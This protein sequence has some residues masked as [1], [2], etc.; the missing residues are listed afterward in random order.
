VTIC[1]KLLA[2]I[3]AFLSAL[4][5][6][7]AQQS[8]K[9]HRV[10]ELVL[11]GGSS[12]L[13]T[14]RE[15]FRRELHGL[16]YIEGKNIY[17]ETRSAEGNA[18][19]FNA[20]AEEL[21]RLKV[22]AIL[23]TSPAET[24]AARRATT[25]IPIVFLAQGDPVLSGLVD[26][27]SRPGGNVTGVTTVAAGLSGKRLELLKEVMPKLFRAAVLWNPQGAGEGWKESQLAAKEL[28]LQLHSMQVNSADGVESTFKEALKA[29]SAAFAV[30]QNP[31]TSIISKQVI[32][33]ARTHP[34]PTIFPRGDYVVNGGL[35]S[36]GA[37]QVESFRRAAH[38]VDKI[39]KGTKPGDLPV[40]RPTK[41]YLTISLK[42][43]KQIG[44]AISPN[45]LA[46]ADRVIK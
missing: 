26:S 41:F 37:E 40:E 18:D 46:R 32:A 42:T 13:G 28:G 39:L 27:L 4:S 9:V 31:L 38:T 17:Y 6:V 3:F 7:H 19:R 10:G 20:L 44:L 14:G 5:S 12:P 33:L 24:A 2:F 11:V 22:H 34:M 35:M 25:T 8:A 15:I 29:G 23:T 21:V 43:A 30:T 1:R 36:Y 16:G 45:V